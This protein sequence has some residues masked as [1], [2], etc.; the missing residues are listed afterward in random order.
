MLGILKR[1]A[2]VYFFSMLILYVK[3][4]CP[5]CS[6]VLHTAEALGISFNLKNVADPGI[7]DELIARG[8]KLQAPYLVDEERGIE[9]YESDDIIEH[10]HQTFSAPV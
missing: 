8:G 5:Y 7:A 10:L 3:T 6:K 4:G 2:A 9:L 1:I